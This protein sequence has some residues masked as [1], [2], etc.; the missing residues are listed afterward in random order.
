[1]QYVYYACDWVIQHLKPSPK[2]VFRKLYEQGVERDCLFLAGAETLS[3]REDGVHV[4]QFLW[5]AP[6]LEKLKECWKSIEADI[7][8]SN[9]KI[10]PEQSF[11]GVGDPHAIARIRVGSDFNVYMDRMADENEEIL[12]RKL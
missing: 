3:T 10:I 8:F 6:S 12:N 7:Q 2:A 9:Y 1:M 5:Q 11:V 4:L